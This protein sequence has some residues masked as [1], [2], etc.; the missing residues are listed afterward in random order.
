MTIEQIYSVI[1]TSASQGMCSM[2][3]SLARLH[4]KN[5]IDK[6]VALKLS[7]RMNE[8]ERQLERNK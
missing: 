4:K 5:L 3:D 8:L 7:P 1:Q 2:N 6:E